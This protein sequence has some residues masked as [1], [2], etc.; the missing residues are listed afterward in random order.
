MLH[1]RLSAARPIPARKCSVNAAPTMAMMRATASV[2]STNMPTTT[3]TF[4]NNAQ[5]W[6][7]SG[8]MAPFQNVK[9]RQEHRA[10]PQRLHTSSPH[11]HRT[12]RIRKEG[13]EEP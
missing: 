13:G 8:T 12:M 7:A 6:D 1:P 10:V 5:A 9:F 4:A 3:A 11:H 2:P